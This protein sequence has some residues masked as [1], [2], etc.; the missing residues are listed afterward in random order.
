VAGQS[1]VNDTQCQSFSV[2][3]TGRQW[4]TDAG[5]NDTTTFCWNN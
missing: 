5:G 1:Q 3:N 2:D 4:A